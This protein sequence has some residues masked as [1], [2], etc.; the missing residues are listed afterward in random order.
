MKKTIL[1]FGVSSFMGSNL[2]QILSE[3][4]RIIGTYHNTPV[5]IPGITCVPCDVLKKEYVTKLTAIFKPDITIYAVGMSSLKE[6]KMN[7]KRA[8]A[9]NS[10]GAV[11]CSSA[12]ER[13]GS[14]FIFL[15]SCF[16]LGGEDTLYRESDTPFPVTAYGNSLSSTEFYI[17]RSCLNYLILRCAPLYGR[18]FNPLHPNWFEVVQA[19]LAKN[20]TLPADDTVSIGFLDIYVLGKILKSLIES[21]ISNRLLQVSS[22]DTLSRYAFAKLYAQ[23]F[24]KD[25]NLIQSTMGTFPVEKDQKGNS[26]ASAKN[27]F[28]QMDTTNLETIIGADMPKIEESLRLTYQRLRV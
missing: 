7:P 13:Y 17:Q 20:Q 9:L 8:D 22:K 12:S 27:Y 3:D 25:E 14:K 11:N 28:F 16:V 5:T 18:S 2:A 21:G 10:A 4:F 26:K 24:K 23:I 6:C 19:A 1:I 15:S